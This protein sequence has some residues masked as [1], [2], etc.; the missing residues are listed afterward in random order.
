MRALALRPAIPA[1]VFG[2]AGVL[3]RAARVAGVPAPPADRVRAVTG[4]SADEVRPGQPG[5]ISGRAQVA[6]LKAATE[7]VLQGQARGLVTAPISKEW[8]GR[9]GFQF[10]GHTE[11]LADAA[12]VKDFAM[13]L[14]GP[15]L[16]VTLATIHLALQ[17]DAAAADGRGHRLGRRADGARLARQLRD[18][19]AAGGD[20]RPESPRRRGRTLRGRG[21]PPGPARRRRDPA[22][23]GGCRHARRRSA[24]RTF[25]TPCFARPPWEVS[26]PWWR[27]ITTRG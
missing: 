3:A 6:Y 24:G 1:L 27:C 12:G 13:M 9:A 10:P 18:P 23:P 2:D 26:T 16:R 7:A 21:T 15:Q 25:R 4:L 11:F 8:A 17:R 20:R 5:E 19:R 22:A 14:A